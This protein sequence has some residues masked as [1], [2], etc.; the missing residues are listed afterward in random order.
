MLEV[1][2]KAPDFT[3]KAGRGKEKVGENISLS[4]LTKDKNVVLAFFPLAYTGGCTNE[5]TAFGVDLQRFRDAG[6][7]V[8]G[9]SVDSAWVLDKFAESTGFNG[10][11]VSDF[12]KEISAAY[13]VL[14]P[15]MIGLKG[16]AKR[17]VYVVDK[18]GTIR[19]AWLAGQGQLPSN[20]EV[21]DVLRKL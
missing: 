13:G 21:L 6:A 17:A 19:Y 20:E 4:E 14:N 2:Q 11:M 5:M 9:I 8:V 7:E 12:N 3:A 1:G 16:V 15:E 10:V 18:S